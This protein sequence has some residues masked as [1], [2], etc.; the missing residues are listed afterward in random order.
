MLM[1]DLLRLNVYMIN[2][3][4]TLAYVWCNIKIYPAYR[5]AYNVERHDK[6]NA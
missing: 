2:T 6:A 5:Q 1:F 3:K 4:L